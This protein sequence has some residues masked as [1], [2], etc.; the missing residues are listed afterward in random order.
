MSKNIKL[1]VIF[2][3]LFYFFL[4]WSGSFFFTLGLITGRFLWAALLT[5]VLHFCYWKVLK[6][7][8]VPQLKFDWSLVRLI[9][10]V[11]IAI[12]VI[13]IGSSFFSGVKDELK[14]N[15]ERKITL[16]C[17]ILGYNAEDK[18]E[19]EEFS[20]ALIGIYSPSK[21]KFLT[22]GEAKSASEDVD[23][24]IF[25]LEEAVELL[26]KNASLPEWIESSEK[27][28]YWARPQKTVRVIGDK[29]V[30]SSFYSSGYEL[31]NAVITGVNKDSNPLDTTPLEAVEE[32][33]VKN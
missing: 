7:Q 28:N 6:K 32:Y 24:E 14:R 10:I 22:I 25:S 27:R 1:H 30:K 31:I 5:A 17:V 4:N 18:G 19:I 33:E 15:N 20:N 3:F 2:L 11:A 21:K 29:V 23:Y 8:S 12:S 16:N 26:E 13:N 9:L